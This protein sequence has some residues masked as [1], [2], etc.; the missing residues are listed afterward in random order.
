M[1][2]SPWDDMEEKKKSN[3]QERLQVLMDWTEVVQPIPSNAVSFAPPDAPLQLMS[4]QAH[5]H[6]HGTRGNKE[7]ARFQPP[8]MGKMFGV[9]WHQSYEKGKKVA[10][11]A[12]REG[13]HERCV[14]AP[15]VTQDLSSCVF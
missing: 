6:P 10:A 4:P 2:F 9:G 5:K 13:R 12:P 15:H 8:P 1:T 7:P 3:I 14:F 11:Y